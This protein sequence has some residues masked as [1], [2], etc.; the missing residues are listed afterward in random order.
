MCKACDCFEVEIS[1][2]GCGV[3]ND[4]GC[5]VCDFSEFVSVAGG[6]HVVEAG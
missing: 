5:G 6:E 1:E 2:I 4:F 3:M